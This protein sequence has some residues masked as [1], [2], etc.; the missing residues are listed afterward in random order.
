MGPSAP[1]SA[2]GWL[3]GGGRGRARGATRRRRGRSPPRWGR[4]AGGGRAGARRGA[5][6]RAAWRGVAVDASQRD[7]CRAALQG[8]G[9]AVDCAGPFNER[10]AAVLEACLEAGCHYVDISDDRG[11]AA[12]VRRQ[13]ERFRACGLTAVFGCSSL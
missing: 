11:Y 12:L 8:H 4:G 1:M 6:A 7:A 9:V 10:N 2:V 3:A 13:R 5:A